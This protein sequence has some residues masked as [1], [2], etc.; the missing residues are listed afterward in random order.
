[1]GQATELHLGAEAFSMPDYRIWQAL[2]REA[3]FNRA[4]VGGTFDLPHRGHLAL[5]ARVRRLARQTVLSLNT[6]DFA[7][8]Y[9]RRPLMPL[10]DRR[11]IWST[12]RLV[13]EVVVNVGD[14]DSRPAILYARADCVIHGSDWAGASLQRQM[15]LS[16]E[17]LDAHRV[18]VVILPYTGF[19]STT[20]LLQERAV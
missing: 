5:L 9:K 14:E 13:D 15:G 18:K 4:Y 11:A 7:G 17:W 10:E 3:P 1:M 6:D 8:R 2:G 19:V 20:Q 16:S 12:C